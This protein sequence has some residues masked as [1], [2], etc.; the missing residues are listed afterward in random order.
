M[1]VEK[2]IENNVVLDQ[3]GN[4]DIDYYETKAQQLRNEYIADFFAKIGAKLS[5]LSRDAFL[6]H[7]KNA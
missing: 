5:K 7:Y 3:F 1:K 6:P 4:V 2:A